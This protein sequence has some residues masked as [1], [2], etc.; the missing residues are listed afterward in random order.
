MAAKIAGVAGGEVF[1]E[2][3]AVGQGV[4]HGRGSSA[5]ELRVRYSE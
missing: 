5:S 3:A 4:F 2:E 1:G